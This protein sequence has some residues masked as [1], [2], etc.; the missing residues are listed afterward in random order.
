MAKKKDQKTVRQTKKAN[1]KKSIRLRLNNSNVIRTSK[2]AQDKSYSLN[3]VINRL[4]EIQGIIDRANLNYQ[5]HTSSDHICVFNEM[6][7]HE[8]VNWMSLTQLKF[9]KN[10]TKFNYSLLQTIVEDKSK[11]RMFNVAEITKRLNEHPVSKTYSSQTVRLRMKELGFRFIKPV[12]MSSSLT[13]KKS[14]KE[15]LVLFNEFS[16]LIESNH[17]FI[18]IDEMYMGGRIASG[19]EWVNVKSKTMFTQKKFIGSLS[20]IMAVTRTQVLHYQILDSTVTSDKFYGFIDTLIEVIQGH[21]TYKDFLH[22]G[23]LVIFMDNCTVHTKVLHLNALSRTPIKVLFNS[24]YEPRTNMIEYTFGLLKRHIRANTFDS[25]EIRIESVKHA[26]SILTADKLGRYFN[27]TLRV[28]QDELR[29][30]RSSEFISC[31]RD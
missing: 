18:F 15:K 28:F 8:T 30:L 23:K 2:L 22:Q 9:I 29:L 5:T 1:Q 24:P 20:I 4:P 13:T 7:R 14:F 11:T 6:L 19:K 16:K 26:I 21:H 25:K 12:R 17:E 27:K 10:R 31:L 3:E